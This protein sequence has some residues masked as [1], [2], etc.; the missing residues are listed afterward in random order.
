VPSLHP[1]DVWQVVVGDRLTDP[2]WVAINVSKGSCLTVPPDKIATLSNLQ[3]SHAAL[4]A[5]FTPFGFNHTVVVGATLTDIDITPTATSS[6]YHSLTING[7]PRRSGAAYS[8]QL[9]MGD[10]TLSWTPVASPL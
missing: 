2:N 1:T 9:E 8:A 7:V 10:N 5:G 6:R 4:D 3:V